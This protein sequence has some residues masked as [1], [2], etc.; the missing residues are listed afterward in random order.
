MLLGSFWPDLDEFD[1]RKVRGAQIRYEKNFDFLQFRDH[2]DPGND[3]NKDICSFC[4]SH[5]II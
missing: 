4:E 5:E 3:A 2:R 1:V